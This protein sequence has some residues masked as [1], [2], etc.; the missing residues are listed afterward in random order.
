MNVDDISLNPSQQAIIGALMHAGTT[1][2]RTVCSRTRRSWAAV[3][4][5]TSQLQEMGLLANLEEHDDT[6]RG[7]KPGILRLN[8]K[9]YLAGVSVTLRHL[10]LLVTSLDGVIQ[11]METLPLPADHDP[12]V[13]ILP[14]LRVILARWRPLL[15]IGISFPGLIGADKR[16]VVYSVHFADYHDRPLAEEIR[17]GLQADLPVLVERNAVCALTSLKMRRRLNGDTLLISLVTGV[18]AAVYIDGQILHGHSGNIGEL[19]HLPSA[20][21]ANIPCAC[22]KIGCIETEIGGRTWARLWRE[23]CPDAAATLSFHDAVR[24]GHATAVRL[25]IDS[26]PALFPSLAQLVLLLRPDRLAIIASLPA[27]AQSHFEQAL[28]PLF[29]AYGATMPPELVFLPDEEGHTA[30]GAAGLN[31]LRLAGTAC[32]C[33]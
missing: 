29:E 10:L 31:L 32:Y 19:G 18:S 23:A 2:R 5:A 8:P 22:G 9:A 15:G 13:A 14:P 20:T 28:P 6:E 33:R 7:R 30:L 3:S 4:K 1:T 16:S 12:A 24:Q 17:I 27:S 21:G 25:L 11:T 26:L